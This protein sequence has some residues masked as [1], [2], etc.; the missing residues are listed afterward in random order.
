M[1]NKFDLGVFRTSEERINMA[2][3]KECPLKILN[4]FINEDV[5]D[6]VVESTI[7]NYKT[8]KEMIK[9]VSKRLDIEYEELIKR[10]KD[11]LDL[12]DEVIEKINN[13]SNTLC[14][15]PWTHAATYSN[16]HIRM[17]CQMIYDDPVMPFG[18]L[19]KK[20]GDPLK[21]KD[22]INDY[23][24]VNGLKKIRKEFLEGEKPSICKLCWDEE[25]NKKDKSSQRTYE[26]SRHKNIIPDIIKNTKKDGSIRNEDFPI[27]SWDLRFGNKCNLKCR[28]CG[29]MD[30]NQWYS[31]W[32]KMSNKNNLP[33]IQNQNE[34]KLVENED[35][36]LSLNIPNY[37]S[38]YED[39][40][41]WNEI[42][43]NLENIKY[44]YFT[45]GEPTINEK[46]KELLQIIIDKKL[47][48]SVSIRYN[49]NMAAVPNKIFELW[50]YFNI[51]NLGMSIDG[52]KEHFEYIRHP[53]L[54]KA[55]ERQLNKIDNDIG[56]EN[57][58]AH[59]TVTLSVMNV[60][61][62][63]DMHDYMYDV[64]WNRINSNPIVHCLRGP[65]YFNIQNI[66]LEGKNYI[67]EK[68]NS[69]I[70]KINKGDYKRYWK[71]KTITT[72]TDIIKFMYAEDDDIEKWKQ[73]RSKLEQLDSIRKEN[74]ENSLPEIKNVI[75]ITN[76]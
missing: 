21:S 43:D 63:L 33:P 11:R 55:T 71:S 45:G 5:D 35:N 6:S 34:L 27:K 52:I 29:P 16:G 31:D 58:T 56:L 1:N 61:H 32:I 49:T 25:K 9:R 23:R 37:F 19:Y 20:D 8:T 12:S 69:Y 59:F 51:V 76:D 60:L 47:A 40:K 65:E 36:T 48:K 57:V 7:Y 4:V 30:S 70:E 46:H 75:E 66:P 2:L 54:W 13:L 24:N 39:S 28:T 44:Y 42:L 50:S 72:L 64:N 73:F 53:G 26:L 3:D 15:V 22:G 41:L 68:Y 38:W 62:I 74:W 14:T 10:R 67:S 18:N 17:C